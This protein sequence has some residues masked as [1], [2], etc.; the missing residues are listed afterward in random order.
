M[1]IVQSMYKL[2]SQMA[3]PFN[4]LLLRIKLLLEVNVF[5]WFLLKGVTNK[6]QSPKTEG[7]MK[8]VIFVTTKKPSNI[9]FF[10]SVM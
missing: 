8:S 7:V 2:V 6:I 1:F 9:C 4:K 3:M 5:V 10:F